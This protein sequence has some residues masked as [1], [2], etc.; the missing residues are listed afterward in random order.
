MNVNSG[1]DSGVDS[2][3]ANLECDVLTLVQAM[4][5][6]RYEYFLQSD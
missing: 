2:G 1:V 4:D 3:V 6:I 5:N